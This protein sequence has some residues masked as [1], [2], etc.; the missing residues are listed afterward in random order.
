MASGHHVK[1]PVGPRGCVFVA[2]SF[3][4]LPFWLS[5]WAGFVLRRFELNFGPMRFFPPLAE[6]VRGGVVLFARG[7]GNPGF[8]AQEATGVLIA[9][10]YPR[11][12]S[13][14]MRILSLMRALQCFRH[15]SCPVSGS[16]NI[17]RLST[18]SY[19]VDSGSRL[20]HPVHPQQVACM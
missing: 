5:S 18:R 20:G 1:G 6:R 13:S 2:A 3:C 8:T 7:L 14:W 16:A 12:P 9:R 4:R 10:Q 11:S 17:D 19:G 15:G